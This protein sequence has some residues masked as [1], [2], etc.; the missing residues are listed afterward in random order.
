MK[1][2]V[3]AGFSVFSKDKI[4]SLLRI[5]N[6][7]ISSEHPSITQKAIGD[8]EK[9]ATYKNGKSRCEVFENTVIKWVVHIKEYVEVVSNLNSETILELGTGAWFG[10]CSLLK[11]GLKGKLFTIDIDYAAVKNAEGLG[12]YFGVEDKIN[13]IVANFW[14]LP[15]KDQSIDN[16]CSYYGLDES[17]ETRHVLSEIS[18]IL[19]CDGKS[20]YMASTWLQETMVLNFYLFNAHGDVTALTDAVWTIT[21]SYDYD[22]FGNETNP[23]AAD[24]NQ[25]R[26]CGEYFDKE[27]GTIYLRARYYDPA[28]GRFIT[29]DSYSGDIKD[30]LSLN[31]YMYGHN[32]PVM[33]VDQSGNVIKIT[34]SYDNP[35]FQNFA[36]N[37]LQMPTDQFLFSFVDA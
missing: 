24:D 8:W 2:N 18:R 1:C 28:I 15:F 7:N 5:N 10:K 6:N 21:K 32:N 31:L 27:T 17:R 30:P 13:P 12:K 23:N 37:N 4:K 25:F 36:F 19:R 35:Q 3:L 16:I 11:S 34:N 22:A 29:E 14:Y 33:F 9:Y 20:T 26:Y